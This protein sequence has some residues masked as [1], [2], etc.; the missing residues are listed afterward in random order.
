MRMNHRTIVMLCLCSASALG[1]VVACGGD[2]SKTDG[3][4]LDA[5]TDTGGSDTSTS[6]TST[7]DASTDARADT[8]TGCASDE[9]GCRACCATLYPEA[10]ATIIVDIQACACGDAAACRTPCGANLCKDKAS[11]PQ[12]GMCVANADAGDCLSKATADCLGSASCAPIIS[13][14][15]SCGDGG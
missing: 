13:C 7:N 6:D 12:C 11:S 10:G 1:L 2:D 15:A 4:D 8:S 5:T 3:G 9:A 14:L